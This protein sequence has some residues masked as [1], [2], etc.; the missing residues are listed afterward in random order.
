M[1]RH[2][3][4]PT[5]DHDDKRATARP[6][7]QAEDAGSQGNPEVDEEALAQRQQERTRYEG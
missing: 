3:D 6:G 2:A 4:Q 1:E 7:E 5:D